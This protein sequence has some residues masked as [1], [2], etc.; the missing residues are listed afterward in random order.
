MC[1]IIRKS[2]INIPG[3]DYDKNFTTNPYLRKLACEARTRAALIKRLSFGMP[4]HLLAT[5]ANGLLMGKIL[6]A[7]PATIPIR[8]D[9]ADTG[10]VIITEEINKSIKQTARIIT[11]TKLCD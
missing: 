6:S 4:P 3:V 1:K 2:E 8:I 11:R 10:S 7:A 9:P 5:F